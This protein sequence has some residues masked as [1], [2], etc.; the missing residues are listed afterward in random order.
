VEYGRQGVEI[1]PRVT[2]WLRLPA[3]A[4]LPPVTI[5]KGEHMTPIWSDYR[6]PGTGYGFGDAWGDL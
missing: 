4:L 2:S 3:P 1:S 6:G 5:P